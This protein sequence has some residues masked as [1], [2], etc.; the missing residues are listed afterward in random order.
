MSFGPQ[1]Y[2]DGGSRSPPHYWAWELVILCVRL[3]S[4]LT[5]NVPH[6]QALAF[7]SLV[8]LVLSMTWPGLANAQSAEN[9]RAIYERRCSVCHGDKGNGAFWASGSL[10]PPPRDFTRTDADALSREVMIDTVAH[11]SRGTAMA[12]WRSRLSPAQIAAVVDFIRGEFMPRR[13]AIAPAGAAAQSLPGGLRGDAVKGGIFYHANCAECHGHAG[14]GRGRR[15]DFMFPKPLDFTAAKTTRTF[16]R[17]KLFQSVSRGVPGAAMPAWSKVLNDQQIAD[18][19]EYVYGTF[20]ETGGVAPTRATPGAQ[21][22]DTGGRLYLRYCS[23]CHGINGDGRTAAAQVL[24]PKP[25]ELTG[26][27]QMSVSDVAAAVRGGRSGTAMPSF[28]KVLSEEEI[29]E[30]AAYV[31]Q[32][33]PAREGGHGRYHTAQNGWP[34]HD[35]R[36]GPAA[37]FALGERPVDAPISSL[38]STQREGLVLFKGACVSCHFGKRS[39][40]RV[41]TPISYQNHNPADYGKGPHDKVPEITDL[42]ETESQGRRL[43]QTACAQCH[44]ADGTGKNWIGR[45]LDPSPTNFSSAQS[46]ALLSLEAFVERTLRP[47]EGTSMPSFERILSREQAEAIAA[48]SRRAFQ[49]P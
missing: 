10:N 25:R 43:Y 11:G 30:L 22:S 41:V 21:A 28:S 3:M 5:D 37:P 13:A 38:S 12:A 44:A 39:M 16:D 34:E 15:A 6:G 49:A 23:Y 29:R 27:P 18:V 19:V 46:R 20:I 35:A 32:R 24:D 9:G 7:V 33:L 48:Y 36:Y 40:P 1:G 45:F 14:D 8:A 47:P 42:T 2:A 17:A 31:A 4:G 26:V